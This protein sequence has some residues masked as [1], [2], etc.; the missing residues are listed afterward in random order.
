MNYQITKAIYEAI[1]SCEINGVCSGIKLHDLHHTKISA[2]W[3]VWEVDNYYDVIT[4]YIYQNDVIKF[5]YQVPETKIK[6]D[7]RE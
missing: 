1:K 2:D 6:G 4:V 5:N 7:W 3:E